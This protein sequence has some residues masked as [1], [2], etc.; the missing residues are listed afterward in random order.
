MV[1]EH[2]PP[3]T[4]LLFFVILCVDFSPLLQSLLKTFFRRI[5]ESPVLWQKR[6]LILLLHFKTKFCLDLLSAQFI[7]VRNFMRL[8]LCIWDRCMHAC[9]YR[10]FIATPMCNLSKELLSMHLSRQ[11]KQASDREDD[12]FQDF[13]IIHRAAGHLGATSRLTGGVYLSPLLLLLIY[14][15]WCVLLYQSLSSMSQKSRRQINIFI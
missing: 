13:M 5:K 14:G 11:F 6:I 12:L 10:S 3:H 4:Y 15:F 2:P 1:H 8:N 9:S 7:S